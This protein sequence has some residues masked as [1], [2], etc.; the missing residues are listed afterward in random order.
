MDGTFGILRDGTFPAP[1]D[2]TFEVRAG[3][4]YAAMVLDVKE[5]AETTARTTR[6]ISQ[7]ADGMRKAS[8][9]AGQASGNV[10]SASSALS[11]HIELLRAASAELL[12]A[13]RATT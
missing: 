2:K 1:Q 5:L 11:E 13:V 9:M 10:Q 12:S 6:D 4:S 8:E 7:N 3:K